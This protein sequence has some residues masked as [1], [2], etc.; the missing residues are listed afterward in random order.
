MKRRENNINIVVLLAFGI[1]YL[2]ISIGYGCGAVNSKI[3]LLCSIISFVIALSQIFR[4]IVISLN[5]AEGQVIAMTLCILQAWI[6]E[7]ENVSN[8]KKQDKLKRFNED[9]EKINASYKK[10]KFIFEILE[11]V[12]ILIGTVV[13]IIIVTFDQIPEN[14]KLSDIISLISFALFFFSKAI[15]IKMGVYIE[16]YD[17]SLR[18]I[19]GKI[20]G[21]NE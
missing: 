7:H 5:A 16:E 17:G 21:E 9:N 13:A 15:E 14:P 10:R 12:C 6:L 18:S 3:V 2:I 19:I 11:K 8:E 20:G 4:T 1:A